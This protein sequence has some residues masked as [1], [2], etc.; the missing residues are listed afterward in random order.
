MKARNTR[1]WWFA[2]ALIVATASCAADEAKEPEDEYDYRTLAEQELAEFIEQG[3]ADQVPVPL[4][5][6]KLDLHA[7]KLHQR[8]VAEN[9]RARVATAMT[10]L[11]VASSLFAVEGP[12]DVLLSLF[13]VEKVK[14]AARILRRARE[15]RKKNKRARKL[16]EL[17]DEFRAEFGEDARKYLHL[18]ERLPVE[19]CRPLKVIGRHTGSVK[20]NQTLTHRFLLDQAN[21][22][23]IAERLQKKKLDKDFVR[24]FTFDGDFVAEFTLYDANPSWNTLEKVVKKQPV[25]EG[26]RAWLGR[27][28]K[29]LLGERAAADM[30]RANPKKYLKGDG[31]WLDIGRGVGY[32]PNG[33]SLD[34]VAYGEDGKTLFVEVKNWSGEVWNNA[35]SRARVL[36]QLGDH[37]DGSARLISQTVPRRESVGK[38]LMV[39]ADGFNRMELDEMSK[40]SDKV[41]Q[42][43]WTIEQIPSKKIGNFKELIDGLR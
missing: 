30:I 21:V 19:D 11:I 8:R 37:N 12:A 18:V 25:D 4:A 23:W 31:Q 34:I 36:T 24:R 15:L 28:V 32:G 38:V 29:G 43:G 10:P 17:R 3:L 14:D 2:I 20:V 40:F 9:M 6:D 7:M 35:S 1:T 26:K 16:L 13:P 5:D 39:E 41:K 33:K 27:K 42:L 22:H